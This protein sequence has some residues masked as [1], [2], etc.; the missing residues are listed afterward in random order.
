MSTEIPATVREL[1]EHA[2]KSFNERGIAGA[3]AVMAP[4]VVWANGMKGG[5]VVGHA[6]VR[7]YWK[8]QW[9][10]IDPHVDP[11][12]FHDEDGRV[13]V[14]VKQRV[15][16]LAGGLLTD[17]VVYHVYE[18]EGGFVRGMEIRA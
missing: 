3:L 11:I 9:A 5:V 7:D 18:F 14:T 4:D 10:Q 8:R 1:I 17:G 2:Y 13:V 6:A 15:R 12:D 16:D